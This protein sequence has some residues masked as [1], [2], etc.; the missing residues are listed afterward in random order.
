MDKSS[1]AVIVYLASPAHA[2]YACGRVQTIAELMSIP[3][4]LL[5]QSKK[6]GFSLP[7]AAYYSVKWLY[8]KYLI[9]F[10]S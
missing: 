5:V 6:Y 10:L 9:T 3:L 7:A 2:C 1:A 4:K 8:P